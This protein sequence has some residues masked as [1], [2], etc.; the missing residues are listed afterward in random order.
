[1]VN[2]L[3]DYYETLGVARDATP[4][5]IKLAFRALARL[6]HPDVAKDKV[7]GEARFKV[8]N[9]AYEVLGDAARRLRYDDLLAHPP[10]P[11]AERDGRGARAEGEPDFE[12][13]GTGFSDFFER[14]FG[15]RCS[16]SVAEDRGPEGEPFDRRPVRDLEADLLVTLAEAVKGGRRRVT[17][18]GAAGTGEAARAR[19]YDVH[20]PAGAHEGQRI[21]LAGQGLAGGAG[22]EA[23]DLYL[24]VRLARHPDFEVEGA[25]LACELD[26]APWEAA[27]GVRVAMP[28]L[29]GATSVTVPA[30]SASGTRLRLRGLGLPGTSTGT[31]AGRGA[32]SE[33]AGSRNGNGCA[34]AGGNV[35]AGG[36]GNVRGAAC[37]GRGDLYVTLRILTPGALTE[38]ERGLWEKLAEGSS[39]R[40][41][42]GCGVK[43]EGLKS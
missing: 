43:A 13:G 33:E 15:A 31:S 3:Q 19:T 32:R 18:S 21:R 10:A 24:R 34:G 40:A 17:L 1:M 23:G 30:G 6:H 36:G 12:F 38:A 14:F 27:L 28:T 37:G 8:I 22:R 42:P 9:E 5:Q 20:I 2:T 4:E 25:D 16:R 41:R 7:A 35:G 11:A 26:L 39:F 29:D